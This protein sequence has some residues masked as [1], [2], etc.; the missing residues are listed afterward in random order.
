MTR[1]TGMIAVFALATG[2]GSCGGATTVLGT[3]TERYPS[4]TASVVS[5]VAAKES[6]DIDGDGDGPSVGGRDEDDKTIAGS[7]H[8]ASAADRRA[9][10][11]L[12]ERYSRFARMNDGAGACGLMYRPLAAALPADEGARGYGPAFAQGL[13]TCPAIVSALFEH[14]REEMASPIKA[15]E[16]R[17]R[18]DR[19]LVLLRSPRLPSAYTEVKR[20]GKDWKIDRYV[21]GQFP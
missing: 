21:F 11:T 20:E 1:L 8:P 14:S 6:G 13:K 7:G 15:G 10:A 4:K 2:A 18:G 12:I 17:M 9:V 5:G 16:I 19:A 3:R